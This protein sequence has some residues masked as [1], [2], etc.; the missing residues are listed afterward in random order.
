MGWFNTLKASHH[1]TKIGVKAKLE[2]GE[3]VKKLNELRTLI[4]GLEEGKAA[5]WTPTRVWP[6]S[7]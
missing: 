5:G 2:H 3:L 1:Y 6:R 7:S 4:G